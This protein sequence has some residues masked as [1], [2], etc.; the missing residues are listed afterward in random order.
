MHTHTLGM[1]EEWKLPRLELSV[2]GVTIISVSWR[3][4]CQELQES[5]TPGIHS[6][7][8]R[9]QSSKDKERKKKKENK[10]TYPNTNETFKELKCDNVRYSSPCILTINMNLLYFKTGIEI[11]SKFNILLTCYST[12]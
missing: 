2:T 4:C 3:S 10:L 5:S 9:S 11:C 7:Q 12:S 1:K 6:A 8:V